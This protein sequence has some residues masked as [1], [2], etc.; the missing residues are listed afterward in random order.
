VR[1]GG[2]PAKDPPFVKPEPARLGP[3]TGDEDVALDMPVFHSVVEKFRK[4]FSI[5]RDV[6]AEIAH[7]LFLGNKDA[8]YK[9]FG[10]QLLKGN[11]RV[12]EALANRAYG[13]PNQRVNVQAAPFKLEIVHVGSKQ[14]PQ[15][16]E[17]KVKDEEQLE[18]MEG[19]EDYA[20]RSTHS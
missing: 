6:C 10:K 19:T 13:M 9:A 2:R 4:E 3:Q 5:D 15:T 12:L 18:L 20:A 8:I 11:I 1:R 17:V 7:A 14:E 16:I